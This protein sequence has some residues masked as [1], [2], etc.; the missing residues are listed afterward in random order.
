MKNACFFLLA[1]ET[2]IM[3]ARDNSRATW[4]GD[5]PEPPPR[6]GALLVLG[7][8]LIIA[9]GFFI[10]LFVFPPPAPRTHV[11]VIE[12]TGYGDDYPSLASVW[13]QD[14]PNSRAAS[15][16]PTRNTENVNR[17]LER[18]P[19]PKNTQTNQDTLL[20]VLR[21]HAAADQDGKCSLLI[22]ESD[23]RQYR[24][25][26]FLRKA[27]DRKYR[28]TVIVADICD[29]HYYPHRGYIVNPIVRALKADYE[30]LRASLS[31]QELWLVCAADDGQRSFR[32]RT[33]KTLL[34][35]AVSKTFRTIQESN[36]KD[37]S[38]RDLFEKLRNYCSN[39]SQGLQTPILIAASDS[40]IDARISW[41]D[42]SEKK[43][44]EA[45][46]PVEDEKKQK[47]ADNPDPEPTA[48][49]PEGDAPK[50]TKEKEPSPWEKVDLLRSAKAE[51]EATPFEI[52]PLQW[53]RTLAIQANLDADPNSEIDS[54]A[55]AAF[56]KEIDL[57]KQ[58]FGSELRDRIILDSWSDKA[59]NPLT[60]QE[61]KQWSPTRN[62]L[63]EYMA[64]VAEW[65]AWRDFVL[66]FPRLN[67]NNSALF[68]S[69]ELLDAAKAL[70]KRREELNLTSLECSNAPENWLASLKPSNLNP[71]NDGLEQ[72][73]K[74]L[75]DN[76][77]RQVEQLAKTKADK[78]G[79][80]QEQQ[81]LVL[82]QSPVL[83]HADRERLKD[84]LERTRDVPKT[85]ERSGTFRE[86][87]GETAIKDRF[88]LFFE[89][90]HR[91]AC[92]DL[93][94][95]IEPTVDNYILWGQ[96][97]LKMFGSVPQD[98]QN[99]H[100]LRKWHRLALRDLPADPSKMDRNPEFTLFYPG[101]PDQERL[102]LSPRDEDG[103]WIDLDS[104]ATQEKRFDLALSYALP[105][106]TLG[107]SKL[108]WRLEANATKTDIAK[109]AGFRL[110]LDDGKEWKIDEIR[111]FSTPRVTLSIAPPR[112]ALDSQLGHPDDRLVFEWLNEKDEPLVKEELPI[113]IN[114]ARLDIVVD[115]RGAPKPLYPNRKGELQYSFP[116]IED[117]MVLWDVQLRNKLPKHR[118][119]RVIVSA[120]VN[121]PELARSKPVEWNDTGYVAIE[122]GPVPSAN[123]SPSPTQGAQTPIQTLIF[124]VE[125][126]E[127]RPTSAEGADGS[128]KDS[129]PVNSWPF[130]MSLRPEN[131]S[132][133]VEAD[134]KQVE[135]SANINQVFGLPLRFEDAFWLKV[136]DKEQVPIVARW[137]RK[138]NPD[139]EG[140]YTSSIFRQPARPSEKA[141][142]GKPPVLR[143]GNNELF[144][145]FDLGG[146][147]RSVL[148]RMSCDLD[149]SQAPRISVL[150][151]EP[152]QGIS[153][154]KLKGIVKDH[155]P[156]EPIYLENGIVFPTW[157]WEKENKGEQDQEPTEYKIQGLLVQS[158]GGI[159][160]IYSTIH[161]SLSKGSTAWGNSTFPD[162][163]VV[164]D[165]L[166]WEGSIAFTPSIR[167]A[168]TRIEANLNDPSSSEFDFRVCT[169]VDCNANFWL[170]KLV[171]DREKP[172]RGVLLK[173]SKLDRKLRGDRDYELRV[174]WGGGDPDPGGAGLAEGYLAIQESGA[175]TGP[176]RNS[177]DFKSPWKLKTKGR[178]SGDGK[179]MIFNIKASDL[180]SLNK[181]LPKGPI[182][183]NA[184]IIDRAGNYQEIL[185]E[186]LDLDWE[187][188]SPDKTP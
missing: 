140:T 59:Q 2:S 72:V 49:S 109:I 25:E 96:E 47:E 184:L 166:K 169:S 177:Y 92:E 22:D 114:A 6:L 15:E 101:N 83:E 179:T 50:T 77:R 51:R 70:E 181:D 4:V 24:M 82:L 41:Y 86:W 105:G 36:D 91:F 106:K 110:R 126:L 148:Y 142:A 131:P 115:P 43:W 93:T 62:A 168:Q 137:R 37:F 1:S 98:Q 16:T 113:L 44:Y 60:A 174:D 121:G 7:L 33:G 28:N 107:N 122:F 150:E 99:I 58:Q 167:E 153:E 20:I 10:K 19:L 54:L 53:R 3:A 14:F 87:V 69:K 79:W 120:S 39:Q 170:R 12:I 144:F 17:R 139:W 32:D 29:L 88:T 132:T 61:K 180:E 185:S 129:N 11:E 145:E 26:E 130:T 135:A 68:M 57:P 85:V 103:K 175:R 63:R 75:R 112:D 27:L 35:E 141:M 21:S 66:A 100:P 38:V 81:L 18:I 119:A 71:S 102:M 152:L 116:A 155:P 13:A 56:L 55:I 160:A 178:P 95:P 111:S 124:R 136:P 73:K 162:R 176:N 94:K 173:D 65:V 90:M 156:T 125:E 45:P 143:S 9:L 151:K 163:S 80:L 159:D 34:Q 23:G 164:L 182:R 40:S 108:R 146:Y 188:S 76:L 161:W 133:Y 187:P 78:W 5:A 149:D 48:G 84:L 52:D 127:P 89:A 117:S 97:Y 154:L 186:S 104:N 31:N 118:S 183:I 172:N 171:F 165:E 138:D 46:K 147:S 157:R 30:S 64:F 128:V 42:N 158:V 67:G 8:G 134:R 74:A 123:P